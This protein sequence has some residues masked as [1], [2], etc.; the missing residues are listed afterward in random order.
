MIILEEAKHH[1][2]SAH[3]G[4]LTQRSVHPTVPEC[5]LAVWCVVSNSLHG[6]RLDF[7]FLQIFIKSCFYDKFDTL[8]KKILDEI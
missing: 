3:F 6:G 4:T 1:I 7:F 2:A 8:M 5:A